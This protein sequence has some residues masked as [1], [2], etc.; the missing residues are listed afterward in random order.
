MSDDCSLSDSL[1][2]A[3]GTYDML[4]M[5]LEKNEDSP[6]IPIYIESLCVFLD[7][8]LDNSTPDYWTEE[9]YQWIYDTCLELNPDAV[10]E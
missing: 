7:K 6:N 8:I 9:E 10:S 5:L 3:M 1:A 4:T 2:L